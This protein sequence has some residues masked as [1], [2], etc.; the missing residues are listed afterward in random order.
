[1]LFI[2]VDSKDGSFFDI[3]ELFA[4]SEDCNDIFLFY[5]ISWIIFFKFSISWFKIWFYVCKILFSFD[6]RFM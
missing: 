5:F 1:L 6:C 3:I 4:R 2:I